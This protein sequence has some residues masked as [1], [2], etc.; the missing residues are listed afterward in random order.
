M[1]LAGRQSLRDTLEIIE[2]LDVKTVRAWSIALIEGLQHYHRHG[3]AHGSLHLSNVLLDKGETEQGGRKITV[4][5]LADGGYQRDLHV[6]ARG[7][8]P[9]VSPLAWG[10]PESINNTLDSEALPAT[11][12]WEFGLC[13]L[14]MAFGLGV[15][16]D[17]QSPAALMEELTLTKSLQAMLRQIFN[18]DA[19]KRPSAWDLLHFEFFRNDDTLLEE[20]P[21]LGS[22][23][24]HGA[25][26]LRLVDSQR[27]HPR[28][29][30]HTGS[31]SSR[32]GKEFVEEGRLGRGGFGEV[33][34]A[35][36]KVDG[37]PYAIKKIKARSKSALDPV[38]SEVTVLS[39]LNHPNVVRYFTSWIED[40]IFQTLSESDSSSD[41]DSF[42]IT[43]S[44]RRP[45]LPASSRGLD[46]ISSNNAN[47]VF[48]H[49]PNEDDEGEGYSVSGSSDAEDAGQDLESTDESGE[50]D[51][52][53][54]DELSPNDE[55]TGRT[56]SQE[57]ITW[58]VLYIQMEYCK[59]EVSRFPN[60]VS[61]PELR[62]ARSPLLLDPL[63]STFLP[64]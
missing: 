18:N 34:R 12:I 58:T 7:T 5:K 14:Q 53:H 30:S 25:S 10:A 59:P 24:I 41:D 17:H 61:C 35:R 4:V 49:D 28:R 48:G 26:S 51:L 29:D 16:N 1:E 56:S 38:L 40:S 22:S 20:A 43:D 27:L 37:Q 6:L 50:E 9:L 55:Q 23:S 8:A 3:S 36:N 57:Q 47:V 15:L 11:D 33:F 21:L 52:K 45:V 60:P 46:F 13:F 64:F 31:L 42:M 19:K 32:Y 54:A 62:R 44:R 63:L 39:R 2:K